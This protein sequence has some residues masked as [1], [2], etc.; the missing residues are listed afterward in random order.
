[1][2]AAKL[3]LNSTQVGSTTYLTVTRHPNGPAPKRKRGRIIPARDFSASCYE[4][5]GHEEPGKGG[6]CIMHNCQCPCHRH[7]RADG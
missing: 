5:D 7:K 4:G 6:G 3:Q 1:M 2:A